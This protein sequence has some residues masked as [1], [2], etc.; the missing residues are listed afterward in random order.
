[1][2]LGA[3]SAHYEGDSEAP[4]WASEIRLSGWAPEEDAGRNF[5]AC[6]RC[7]SSESPVMFQGQGA[8][9]SG[10][11]LAGREQMDQSSGV[12]TT[13]SQLRRMCSV[14]NVVVVEHARFFLGEDLYPP[15]SVG[16]SLE[17]RTLQPMLVAERFLTLCGSTPREGGGSR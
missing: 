5:R 3:R 15:C 2:T 17:Q 8:V 11:A 1:M 6:V 13:P 7:P 14:P 12:R 4:I 9:A 10:S 16:E